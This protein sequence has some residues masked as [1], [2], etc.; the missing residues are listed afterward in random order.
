M[1]PWAARARAR[2]APHRGVLAAA[3]DSKSPRFLLRSELCIAYL[4]LQQSCWIC[5][6]YSTGRGGCGIMMLLL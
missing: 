3:P 1:T 6:L 2:Q 5:G 4:L